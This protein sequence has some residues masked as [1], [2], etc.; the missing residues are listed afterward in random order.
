MSYGTPWGA[1]SAQP[2]PVGVPRHTGTPAP[3][4]AW[5]AYPQVGMPMG[6]PAPVLQ[7]R[8]WATPVPAGAWEPRWMP[9]VVLGMERGTLAALLGVVLLVGCIGAFVG[10]SSQRLFSPTVT[11]PTTV[12]VQATRPPLQVLPPALPDMRWEREPTLPQLQARP[13]VVAPQPAP[14][15]VAAP[16]PRRAPF[17][18]ES[19]DVR[20]PWA[21]E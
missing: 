9:A 19:S 7:G 15:P 14:A 8:T 11:A 13:M 1:W 3:V 17:S 4:A 21:D 20:D 6:T 16:V 12:P 2:T 10:A 18:V 5:A